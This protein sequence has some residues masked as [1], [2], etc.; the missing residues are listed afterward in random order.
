MQ[1]KETKYPE[2][3]PHVTE[4]YTNGMQVRDI[5][6]KYGIATS[7]VYRMVNYNGISKRTKRTSNNE[8]VKVCPK[9]HKKVL[10]A[11]ARY[12]P[13]CAT[14]IRSKGELL[15]E[16]LMKLCEY[17]YCIPDQIKDEYIN[18]LNEAAKIVSEK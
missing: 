8:N 17:A 1:F 13:F 15:A 3:V 18:T 4:D 12:C 11:G 16:R 9:C 10:V 6:K 5:C 14:D 7:T 2:L